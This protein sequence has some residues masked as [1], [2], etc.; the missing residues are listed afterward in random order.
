MK[1]LALASLLSATAILL[2][3]GEAR[4]GARVSCREAWKNQ[5]ADFDFKESY[6]DYI[7]R[8][9]RG[10]CEKDWTILVYMAADNNLFPFALWDLYEMEAAYRTKDRAGSTPKVDLV[11]QVDGTAPDDLRRLHIYSGPVQYAP[12][13]KDDF[14]SATLDDVKSPIIEKLD[15]KKNDSEKRRLEDFLVW[16]QEKYPSK[17]YMVVVWGHGQGWKSYPVEEKAPTRLL[18]RTELPKFP[19]PKP[20]SRFGGIAFRES[21]GDWLD[22]PAL[23]DVLGTFKAITGKRIDIYA[24]DACLMQMLEVR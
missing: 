18:E 3:A 6:Q 8:V 9:H 1:W 16:A 22:I 15:E 13:Q 17:N 20:D 5:R 14:T 11:V 4:A 10:E 2:S 7:A 19:A 21:S 12:R 24:S 23:R